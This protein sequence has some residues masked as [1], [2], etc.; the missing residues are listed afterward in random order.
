[1]KPDKILFVDDEAMALKYFERLVGPLAPVIT[2][3]SV[4]AGKAILR[5]RGA[6]IAVL[7]SDQRMPGERGNGT[8]TLGRHHAQQPTAPRQAPGMCGAGH[9][10][11]ESCPLGGRQTLALLLRRA[12]V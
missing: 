7:V 9:E 2:A 4:E 11:P 10:F 6:E 3:A 12:T 1:M 5:E 8:P